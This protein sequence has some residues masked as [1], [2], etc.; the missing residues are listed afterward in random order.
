MSNMLYA[1]SILYKTKLPMILVFNKT[2]VKDATF[3][4][5][6]MTDYE[7]FQEAL[8]QDESNNAFGGYEGA[9]EGG[10]GGSGYMGSLL[11]SMSLMLE[12]FYAH[13]SFVAVSSRLGTGIDEFFEAVG[14]KRDEFMRDYQPELERRRKERD[15]EKVKGREKELQKLMQGMSVDAGTAQ[16]KIPTGDDDDDGVALPSDGDDDDVEDDEN[17]REGLQ[18]RYEAAMA[19][20]DDS[21]MADASFAK[22]LH[23]Q[24]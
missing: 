16:V 8:R 9:G 18:A 4:K 19:D 11:N 7:A 21:V 12:E 14:E 15:E 10:V 5:E 20:K 2:D 23:T 3:A 13:L 1:C 6:W 24:R 22:Y 17:D